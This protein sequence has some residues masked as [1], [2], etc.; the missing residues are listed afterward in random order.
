MMPVA[1]VARQARRL[2]TK[3]STYFAAT[4]F[5]GQ[6]LESRTVD[7]TG[8]RASQIVVNDDDSLET[9]GAGAIWEAELKT[10]AFLVV[11]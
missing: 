3:Y 5:R 1:T 10:S 6:T 7:Q 8:T 4:Y 11:D 9:Q 2:N